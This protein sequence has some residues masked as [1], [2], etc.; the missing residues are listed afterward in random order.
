MYIGMKRMRTINIRVMR[1]CV[2]MSAVMSGMMTSRMG[3]TRRSRMMI[4]RTTMTWMM[5]KRMLK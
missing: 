5:R 4:M 3:S 2:I 1:R